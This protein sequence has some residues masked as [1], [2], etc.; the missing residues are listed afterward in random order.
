[1]VVAP[2]SR[3]LDAPNLLAA[4]TMAGF[5][6]VVRLVSEI[7]RQ[8][9]AWSPFW[10]DTADGREPIVQRMVVFGSLIALG[11]EALQHI[12]EQG[13]NFHFRRKKESVP[14]PHNP[15]QHLDE[16]ATIDKV[17]IGCNK[18]LTVF[19]VYHL[20]QAS[21]LF[22]H[23]KWGLDEF[24]F[25]NTGGALILFFFIYDF[26]Y[27]TFHW[28]LHWPSLYRL[29]HM[30]HHRQISPT[31]GNYD[32]INVHPFEFLVGEYNHLFVVWLVPCH[33]ATILSFLICGGVLAS[34]NHTRLD[35]QIP[36]FYDV[37]NHDVHHRWP[38]SNYGQYTMF[39]DRVF[40][41]YRDYAPPHLPKKPSSN[42]LSAESSKAKVP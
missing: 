26:G 41:W 17:F 15:N 29:V 13:V 33:A 18:L 6:Y 31:R 39:W 21:L 40:G 28:I 24:T 23:V 11:M 7:E 27:A 16:L 9:T 10:R 2:P 5:L 19:F 3:A 30:H 34:L 25:M 8:Q 4:A 22:S 20:T 32:A 36:G 35:L 1:M 12:V 14:L 37:R 42:Q 38:R